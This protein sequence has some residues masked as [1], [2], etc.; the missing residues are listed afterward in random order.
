M[1]Y[2]VQTWFGFSSPKGITLDNYNNIY[3]GNSVSGTIS[4]IISAGVLTLNWL[5][6]LSYTPY[7][8]AFN[9]T[10]QMLYM[11]TGISYITTISVQGGVGAQSSTFMG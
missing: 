6:G 7:G 10:Y 11:G 1:V 9:P 8:L 2:Y 3:I 5:N 4:L